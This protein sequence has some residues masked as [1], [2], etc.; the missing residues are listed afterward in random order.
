MIAA[1]EA[2]RKIQRALAAVPGMAA[3]RSEVEKL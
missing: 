2:E 3:L 1:E